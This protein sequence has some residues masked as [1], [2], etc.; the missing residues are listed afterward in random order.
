MTTRADAWAI[1]AGGGTAGHVTPGLSIA[2][3]IERRGVPADQIRWVG[4]ERGI[5]ARLVPEAGFPLELLP[6]R[7]IQRRLTLANVGAIVGLI[8][9][10]FQALVMVRRARPAVVVGLG[11]YASVP[12][13]LAAVVWRVPIVVAEQNAVPG[14]ANRLAARFA[15]ACALSFPETD[16]RRGTW[17]GNPVRPEILA[18]D[19][20]ADQASARAR[21]GIENG[22]TL[23][24]VFGGSLGARRINNALLDALPGWRDRADLSVRLV[25]GSRDHG[26]LNERNPIDTDD[27]VQFVLVEYED[28]MPS[29]YG[30]A[31]LVICRSGA[32]SVAELAAIGVPAILVPLPGA[33][34]DHQTANARALVDAGAAVMIA[35]GDLDGARLRIEAEALINRPERL[36]DMS[37][38]A[39]SIARRD[40]SEALVD[41]VVAHARRPL[42]SREEAA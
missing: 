8:R 24:A 3:E 30:A 9:A 33:P 18:V 2:R 5:E 25:G 29:V 34:G 4:S 35:D 41:L 16:L 37:E 21:L 20:G 1:I 42:P 14:A 36:Q 10:M 22:R 27:P 32:S 40:A 7:G 28:D 23:I 6:G 26:D 39:R 38:R 13:V 17:T 19:R 12:C 15:K 31:D 11:G